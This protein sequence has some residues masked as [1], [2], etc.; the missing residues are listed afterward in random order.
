MDGVGRSW[1]ARE[2]CERI[3]EMKKEGLHGQALAAGVE[4]ACAECMKTHEFA[5]GCRRE[6][7]PV[8]RA[9]GGFMRLHD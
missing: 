2:G 5:E 4:T 6:Q 3:E 9:L 8:A 1:T 7:S